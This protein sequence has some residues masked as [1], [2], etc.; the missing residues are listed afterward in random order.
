MTMEKSAIA[1]KMSNGTG[2]FIRDYMF[3]K[4]RGTP[5]K[6]SANS[7]ALTG[8]S[9]KRSTCWKTRSE[10]LKGAEARTKLTMTRA[11]IVKQRA[12]IRCI[13]IEDLKNRS[14]PFTGSGIGHR[15]VCGSFRQGRRAGSPVCPAGKRADPCQC[16]LK[17]DLGDR[18]ERLEELEKKPGCW[19]ITR[20]SGRKIPQ[21]LRRWEND[22]IVADYHQ[23]PAAE[24]DWRILHRTGDTGAVSGAAQPSGRGTPEYRGRVRNLSRAGA[25]DCPKT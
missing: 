6:R 3:P 4:K 20:H 17:S 2:Q 24:F 9:K 7:W 8:T 5:L 15:S 25:A 14:M 1:L 21:G 13:D 11:D 23:Q 10:C 22:E 16:G 18:Q 19:R 12:V